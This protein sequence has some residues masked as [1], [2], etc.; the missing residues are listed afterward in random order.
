M[1]AV[2]RLPFTTAG[3]PGAEPEGGRMRNLWTGV[4]AAVVA[5]IVAVPAWAVEAPRYDPSPNMPDTGAMEPSVK[6]RDVAPPDAVG[7]QGRHRAAPTDEDTRD[8][9]QPDTDQGAPDSADKN[10]NPRVGTP[11][12]PR[13]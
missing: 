5:G 8:G 2:H 11:P 10:P 4:L 1:H 13:Y 3:T 6:G 7:S 9:T 12:N